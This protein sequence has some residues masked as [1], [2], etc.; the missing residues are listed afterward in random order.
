MPK[1][2]TEIQVKALL[3]TLHFLSKYATRINVGIPNHCIMY[4]CMGVKSF[5]K[6]TADINTKIAS[7]AVHSDIIVFLYCIICQ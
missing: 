6:K 4:F 3:A 5:V 2:F 7:A 1:Q